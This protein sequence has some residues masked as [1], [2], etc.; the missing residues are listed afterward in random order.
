MIRY[1]FILTIC[2]VTLCSI[3]SVALK[4]SGGRTLKSES[5]YHS[6]IA[7]IQ[8]ATKDNPE[9][10]LLGSSITGRLPDRSH[11][12]VG[13]ANMGCDGGSALDTLRAIHRGDLPTAPLL[14]IEVNTL[15]LGLNAQ[16]SEV[17]RGIGSNWFKLGTHFGP[18]SSTARPS[19][20]AYSILYRWKI[21]STQGPLT[22]ILDTTSKPEICNREY[23]LS[24]KESKLVIE[25][26]GL[27]TDLQMKGC[28]TLLVMLPKAQESDSPNNRM[29]STISK[30]SGVP[31][32]NLASGLGDD[33]IQYSDGV[34]MSPMSAA[35]CMRT[36]K[37]HIDS[38]KSAQE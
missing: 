34:H 18:L 13:I 21:G 8:T 14:I 32:W 1:I 29:A 35:S 9:V 6:S 38:R 5:N 37:D 4:L 19:A 24:F 2:I 22:D 7:R 23:K 20:F 25:I 30:R 26:C 17:S 10:L 12:F 27:I 36:I 3:Q 31:Y 33:A 11:G 15:S 16:K 28:D